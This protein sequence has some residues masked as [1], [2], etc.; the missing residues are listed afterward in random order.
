MEN[1]RAALP[2]WQRHLEDL[3]RDRDDLSAEVIA[4]INSIGRAAIVAPL[5]LARQCNDWV[6]KEALRIESDTFSRDQEG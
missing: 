1:R 4:L 3:M 5:D 2:E 6:G